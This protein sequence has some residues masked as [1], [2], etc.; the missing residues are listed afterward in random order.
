MVT[1][2]YV[3]GRTV[4]IGAYLVR[5]GEPRRFAGRRHGAEVSVRLAGQRVIQKRTGPQHSPILLTG[6]DAL[7]KLLGRAVYTSNSQLG[8]PEI[9]YTN[10]TTHVV[11]DT[12]LQVRG[13]AARAPWRCE[14]SRR[15]AWR[16]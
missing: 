9:M 3:T 10:G 7:N 2:S 12:D 15:R 1:L 8:G 4:G 5:L 16:P 6:Y 13:G 11:V 14:R